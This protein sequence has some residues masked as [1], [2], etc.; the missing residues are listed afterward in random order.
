MWISDPGLAYPLL[1]GLSRVDIK[2]LARAEAISRLAG[3]GFTTPN[4]HHLLVTLLAI[5]YFLSAPLHRTAPS[6]AACFITARTLG[7]ARK[8]NQQYSK[9]NKVQ[10]RPL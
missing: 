1:H 9:I 10:V 7:R 4:L 5:G 2:V 6:E 8:K 3:E